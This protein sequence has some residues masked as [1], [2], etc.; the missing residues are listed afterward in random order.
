MMFN[1]CAC[2]ARIGRIHPLKCIACCKINS[3][4]FIC[5]ASVILRARLSYHILI[6]KTFTLKLIFI[7]L[8]LIL[9][10]HISSGISRSLYAL[11]KLFIMVS[12]FYLTNQSPSYG[13]KKGWKLLEQRS[14]FRRKRNRKPRQL[15]LEWTGNPMM[16]QMTSLWYANLIVKGQYF[17]QY[18]WAWIN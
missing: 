2:T 10:C 14:C 8:D 13:W 4:N 9:F 7:F 1:V 16:V 5:G 6:S 11:C 12:I 3:S 17:E 18:S 15:Q